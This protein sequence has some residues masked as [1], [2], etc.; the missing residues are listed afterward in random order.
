MPISRLG[1]GL[2][3]AFWAANV[4]AHHEAQ[5]L[6]AWIAKV[7]G[8]DRLQAVE[9]GVFGTALLVA[10]GWLAW[11]AGPRI[12]GLV[13]LGNLLAAASFVT[14]AEAIHL[15][16]YALVFGAW[17]RVLKP[18]QA[19]YLTA[20]LGFVDEGLQWAWLDTERA[21]PW[22]DWKDCA[23]NVVGALNGWAAVTAWRRAR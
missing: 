13:A 16:Q 3:M 1:L 8:F 23:L 20:V 19:F 11:R 2:A 17:A 5:V 10:V 7:W 18:R 4:A 15:V 6:F 12:A 21:G 9:A 14:R 22:P